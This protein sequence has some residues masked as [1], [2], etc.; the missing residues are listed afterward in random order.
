[1]AGGKPG[2]HALCL[3]GQIEEL[4]GSPSVQDTQ[5]GVCMAIYIPGSGQGEVQGGPYVLPVPSLHSPA[6]PE[7]AAVLLIPGRKCPLELAD[8]A[9]VF[10]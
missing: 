1:M 2:S 4:E 6:R 10:S 3:S 8:Q 7:S 5:R 9:S